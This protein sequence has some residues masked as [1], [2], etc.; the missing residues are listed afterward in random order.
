MRVATKMASFE[1][2]R[3]CKGNNLKQQLEEE[4]L[5][6]VTPTIDLQWIDGRS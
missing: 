5:G 2:Y 4:E 1:G 6:Y 3:Y